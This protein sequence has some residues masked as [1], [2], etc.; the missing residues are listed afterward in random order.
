MADGGQLANYISLLLL[1]AIGSHGACLAGL[2]P[3]VTDQA[4]LKLT[5]IGLQSVAIKGMHQCSWHNFILFLSR[6]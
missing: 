3:D 2:E 4:G 1:F 5:E 6:F